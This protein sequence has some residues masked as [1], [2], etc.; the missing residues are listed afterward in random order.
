MCFCDGVWEGGMLLGMTEGWPWPRI[1]D[2]TVIFCL[3]DVTE[4]WLVWSEGILWMS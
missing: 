2:V 4:K 3:G 1:W